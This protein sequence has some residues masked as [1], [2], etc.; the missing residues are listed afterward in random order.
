MA[1]VQQ[2]LAH[3]ERRCR[4]RGVRLTDKR[5]QVLTGLL[6]SDK[7]LS[8]YELA[9]YCKNE[10][11]EPIPAMSVYRILDFLQSESLVHR[12]NL[13]NKYVAC[14]HM[15]CANDN[16]VSQF[17]ICGECQRVEEIIIDKSTIAD[18]QD[19]VAHANFHLVSPQ[20][21]L[22]CLCDECFEKVAH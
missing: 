19:N 16:Q 1:A 8:A 7:A 18:L 12:L 10:F 17:L 13:A 6:R 11:D 22:S 20:L 2:I 4:E 14:T 3:A 15:T 9:E 21:E 5:K